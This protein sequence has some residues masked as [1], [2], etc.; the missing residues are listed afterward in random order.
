MAGETAPI[1]APGDL[2]DS[3]DELEGD[4]EGED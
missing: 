3:M 1:S 4:D 2:P